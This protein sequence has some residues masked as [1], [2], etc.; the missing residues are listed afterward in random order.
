MS[1]AK[2]ASMTNL[3]FSF[4]K[5]FNN[6]HHLFFSTIQEEALA[7]RDKKAVISPLSSYGLIRVYGADAK[8]FL[9]GQLSCDLNTVK[10]TTNTFGAY[11]TVKGRIQSFFLLFLEKEPPEECYLLCLP[12]SLIKDTLKEFQK[13]AL[14]SKVTLQDVTNQYSILGLYGKETVLDAIFK[15]VDISFPNAPFNTLKNKDI[16][17]N[18]LPSLES[19]ALVL[20][21]LPIEKTESSWNAFLEHAIIPIGSNAWQ[22]A[23][24]ENKIPVIDA[25]TAGE[26]L[27]HSLDLSILHAV[28]FKKGCYRGQ[29]IVAR[30]EYLGKNKKHLYLGKC[31]TTVLP[32][33]GFMC[34]TSE[35]LEAGQIVNAAWLTPDK[36]LCLLVLQDKFIDKTLLLQDSENTIEIISCIS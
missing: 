4:N 14:F 20:L 12:R 24:I 22:L 8:T 21:I 28:S 25:K 18:R 9:Q 3:P 32:E 2:D 33:N 27:P 11:C 30:M 7:I 15:T 23:L 5:L 19:T 31:H 35:N 1:Q 26:F 6:S 16:I 36:A 13:Y 10:S 17:T 34:T 29:E